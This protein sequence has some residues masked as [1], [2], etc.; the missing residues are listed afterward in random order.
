MQKQNGVLSNGGMPPEHSQ[1][2]SYGIAFPSSRKV[3]VEGRYGVKVPM[4]EIELSG[5]EPPIRVND[6]SGPLG[7]D[8][9]LGIPKLRKSWVLERGGVEEEQT[10]Y[11]PIDPET[12]SE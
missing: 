6:T 4:R 5:G 3:F 9:Q 8:P 2:S 12:A 1:E 10:T 11:S 7:I